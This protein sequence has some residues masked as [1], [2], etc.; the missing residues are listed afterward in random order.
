MSLISS[1]TALVGV[2]GLAYVAGIFL[3]NVLMEIP[4]YADYCIE[5]LQPMAKTSSRTSLLVFYAWI[6]VGTLVALAFRRSRP[7]SQRL[8]LPVI[9]TSYPGVFTLSELLPLL[10][11]LSLLAFNFGFFYIRVDDLL[12]SPAYVARKLVPARRNAFYWTMFTGKL[13]DVA[14]GL[15]MLLA[16][17]NS[18]YRRIFGVSLDAQVWLHRW[19]GYF[20]WIAVAVHTILYIVYTAQY[21][22]LQN[23]ISLLFYGG[24]DPNSHTTGEHAPG[25]GQGNWMVTMGTYSTIFF[26]PVALLSLPLIRR[27]NFELFY[28]AHFLAFPA[29]LFAWLHASSDFYYCIPGLVLYTYDLVL[30]W[31]ATTRK[32]EVVGVR[33]EPEGFVRVDFAWPKGLEQVEGGGG[34]AL[35]AIPQVSRHQWH[36][37]SFAHAPTSPTAT[38]LFRPKPYSPKSWEHLVSSYLSSPS[39]SFPFALPQLSLRLDGPFGGYVNPRGYERVLLIAAGT[40]LAPAIGVGRTAVAA[41]GVS[42]VVLVWG[43]RGGDGVR[44]VSLIEDLCGESRRTNVTVRVS[45]HA[46]PTKLTAPEVVDEKATLTEVVEH[47]HEKEAHEDTTN[48]GSFPDTVTITQ[49]RMDHSAVLSAHVPPTCQSLLIFVCGPRNFATSAMRA[50]RAFI[51]KNKGMRV[52]VSKEGFEF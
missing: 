45:V 43:V 30:R 10:W 13:T 51:A 3:G 29:M 49:G 2:T 18:G 6:A 17:K 47:E 44:G 9:V 31:T 5:N 21:R 1:G 12:N 48:V 16:V 28:Y 4:C 14:L 20:L 23:L 46:T 42:D 37:Y 7:L 26:I 15:S 11:I 34:W 50:V 19:I 8:S 32:V 35:F 41:K 40:G 27:R 24:Y 36:P 39:P 33:K 25:W 52:E 22:T 38:I